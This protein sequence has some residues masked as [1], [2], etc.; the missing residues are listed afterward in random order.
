MQRLLMESAVRA[1][2]IALGTAGVVRLLRAQSAGARHAAWAGVVAVMLVMPQWL[3]WGPRASLRLLPAAPAPAVMTTPIVIAMPIVPAAVYAVLPAPSQTH[4]NWLAIVYLSGA[5]FLLA[6]LVIG[7]LRARAL[8]RGA[9]LRDGRL[10]SSRCAAPVTV[11]ILRPT[12]ILPESWRNWP[13]AQLAA[14]LT[15]EGEHVRRRDPLVQWLALLN[16]AIFW[17]H[18]LAW[19]LERRLSALA[20]EACDA[21]VLDR[22]HDPR[23][24][25]GYLLD[26][27]RAVGESGRR[28][29]LV[30]M[31]MPGSS[32][33]RRV[34][35]ILVGTRAPCLTRARAICLVGACAILSAA[36]AAAN[37]DRRPCV[38]VPPL[39]PAPPAAPAVVPPEPPPAPEPPIE[40]VPVEAPAFM[41]PPPAP[42][43]P[44]EPP[45]PPQQPAGKRLIVLYFDQNGGPLDE[46]AGTS[47]VQNQLR[48]TD[49]VSIMTA[50]DEVKVAQDF[51]ADHDKVIS[52]IQKLAFGGDEVADADRSLDGL[53]T[54]TRMLASISEKKLLVYFM[55]AS[56]RQ[57]LD[58]DQI[59]TLIEAAQRSNVAFYSIDVME[60][61]YQL[62]LG[63]IV[64]VSFNDEPKSQH[65][66]MV[67]PDGTISV[68]SIGSVTA[69]GLTAAQLQSEIVSRA[70]AQMSTPHVTVRVV[71]IHSG[72][73]VRTL[74]K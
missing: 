19:W 23:D 51:T 7:T 69:A 61:G 60:A 14:V 45:A 65:K 32:L 12:A 4:W 40:A 39:P 6:R 18:P 37:V 2:L 15:H 68:P 9:T 26:L 53:L 13:P 73:A 62:A 16:R 58:G 71:S 70:S 52:E 38:P 1:V 24:Y 11:G 42:P 20:E 59:Q 46:A 28:I 67:R 17:F 64:S 66:L 48:S 8:V 21:A 29:N 54:A 33:P 44:P 5:I 43:E 50:G 55:P 27:A 3:A 34:Q 56:R 30:A 25:S 36:F 72:N 49:L 57:R 10:T 31:A 22:G 63:D 74:A 47:F 41:P 35:Q